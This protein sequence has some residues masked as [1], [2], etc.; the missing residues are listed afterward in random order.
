MK[1]PLG[2]AVVGVGRWGTNLLRAIGTIPA[3]RITA[4]CD[5]DRQR[6]EGAGRQLPG[7][8][9][10]TDL[11]ELLGCA[12]IDAVVIATPSDL[13]AAHATQALAGGRHVFVEKPMATGYEDAQRLVE[14]ARDRE[15][16]LMVGHILVHHPSVVALCDHVRR[17]K[18]GRIR[19]IETC[20]LGAAQSTLDAWWTLAP[21]DLSVIR[22][23]L[24]TPERLRLQGFGSP[25]EAQGAGGRRAHEPQTRQVAR[26][27]FAGGATASVTVGVRGRPKTRRIAVVGTRGTAVFDDT[28]ELKLRIQDPSGG[29]VEV[30]PPLGPDQEP[31]VLEMARFVRGITDN[32]DLGSDG[33]SGAE[34]VRLLETGTRSLELGALWVSPTQIESA[35]VDAEPPRKLAPQVVVQAASPLG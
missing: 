31:L 35:A 12:D 26:L 28:Q 27:E 3:A 1:Q 6:L 5:I 9:Q 11:G 22:L 17:G 16:K 33:D 18:L 15:R 10:A 13:H 24:G 14:L 25:P 29:R 32:A 20:R 7:A 4:V 23:L 34:V 19:R 2:V 21:H 8:R 30:L